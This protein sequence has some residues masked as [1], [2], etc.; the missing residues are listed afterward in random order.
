[1]RT[2]VRHGE[3]QT[4]YSDGSFFKGLWVNGKISRSGKYTWKDQTTYFGEW[5]NGMI[6][7]KGILNSRGFTI[8]GTWVANELMGRAT[9]ADAA[10]VE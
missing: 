8:T 7:G 4:Q 10:G 2:N 3:G 6:E 5:S 1:M 9:V